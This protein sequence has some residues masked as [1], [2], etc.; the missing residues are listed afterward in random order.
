[1]MSDPALPTIEKLARDPDAYR[2]A[3]IGFPSARA[4]FTEALR[5]LRLAPGER[6][7]LPAFVGW[8]AREGSGVFDPIRE[9]GLAHAFYRV[10]ER[11]EADVQHVEELL[12]RGDAAV[13]VIIHYFGRAEPQSAAIA[14]LARAHGATL[15]EDEAHALYTDLVAGATGR[16]GDACL[17]SLHK[18]LPQ[19]T[20]GVLL[21]NPSADARLRSLADRDGAGGVALP[22]SWDL[23]GIAARRRENVA[24]LEAALDASLA[25][26]LAEEVEPLWR[27]E[28]DASVLQTYPVL[29]RR[30]SRDALYHAMNAAGF[31]VVS[32]YHTL[33]D[34]LS[35]AEFPASHTLAKRIM[36]LPVHQDATPA[37]MTALVGELGRQLR[38]VP[39]AA[40]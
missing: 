12:R 36:N 31:G 5:A 20:G 37:Q 18:M 4:A 19:P 6:V 39:R 30:A 17:L 35:A 11:L 15:I 34:Q 10:S 22:G 40:T 29:V 8:S 27:A 2:R 28:G 23:A 21:L 9:L 3:A 7:L 24:A 14:A 33:I 26:G 25:E 13:V 1:M 16:L 32:L 38:S